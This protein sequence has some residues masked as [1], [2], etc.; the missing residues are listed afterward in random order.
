MQKIYKRL[1]NLNLSEERLKSPWGGKGIPKEYLLDD[2]N[3]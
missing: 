2:D 1:I 3:R